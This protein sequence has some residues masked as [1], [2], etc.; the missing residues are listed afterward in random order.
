MRCPPVLRPRPQTTSRLPA[1]A[2]PRDDH[3]VARSDI[4]GIIDPISGISQKMRASPV[5]FALPSI[6]QEQ[7]SVLL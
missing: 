5:N 6:H 2:A 1:S 3:G 4:S 7:K